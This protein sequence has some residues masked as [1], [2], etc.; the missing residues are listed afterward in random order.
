MARGDLIGEVGSTKIYGCNYTI[1]CSLD[2]C[3]CNRKKNGMHIG[4]RQL[5]CS[6]GYSVGLDGQVS[7]T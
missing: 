6:V 2:H 3:M 5:R 4:R 7:D 1:K